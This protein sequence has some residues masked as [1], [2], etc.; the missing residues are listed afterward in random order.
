MQAR[1]FAATSRSGQKKLRTKSH[2]TMSSE[3]T[4]I[5]GNPTTFYQLFH[6]PLN[7]AL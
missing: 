3:S 6:T 7:F 2:Q 4:E 1:A 5:N